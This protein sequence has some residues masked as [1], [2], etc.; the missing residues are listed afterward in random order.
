M[1]NT[2][3]LHF[4][5]DIRS[6]TMNGNN[7]ERKEKVLDRAIMFKNNF[8]GELVAKKANKNSQP[9]EGC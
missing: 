2:I 5:V 6:L 3:S 8:E 1:N 7:K 9:Q 4:T